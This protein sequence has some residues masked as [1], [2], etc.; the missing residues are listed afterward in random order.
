MINQ[1]DRSTG[2]D[3]F[4]ALCLR[5]DNV[6][7][8]SCSTTLSLSTAELDQAFARPFRDP[9]GMGLLCAPIAR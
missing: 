8:P 1:E 9:T 4:S 2:L 5:A 3:Y 7:V 6:S